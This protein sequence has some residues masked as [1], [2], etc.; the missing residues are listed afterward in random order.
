[1][2]PSRAVHRARANVVEDD[3]L[4]NRS[5]LSDIRGFGQDEAQPHLGPAYLVAAS[6]RQHR[7][8]SGGS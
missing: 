4:W 8:L 3:S 2:I 7:G 5:G 1:M 6:G